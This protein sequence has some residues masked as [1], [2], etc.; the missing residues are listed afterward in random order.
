MLSCSTRT[1]CRL[2]A[3]PGGWLSRIFKRGNPMSP[4]R[5]ARLAL[6][7]GCMLI[8]LGVA[9]G[10]LVADETKEREEPGLLQVDSQ[11]T[12]VPPLVVRWEL[13]PETKQGILQFRPHRQIYLLPVRYSTATNDQPESPRTGSP[14]EVALDHVEAKFQLS[15]KMKTLENLFGDRADL[16]FAFTQQSSWQ[17]YNDEIS[18]PFRETNYEPEVMLAFATDYNLFGLNGRLLNLGVVH[19]SNGRAEPLSRSWNRVYVQ[20]GLVRDNFTLLVRPWYRL[21]EDRDEDDNRDI[22]EYLGYGDLE[23]VYKRR[24][25]T[26]S[27][28]VRPPLN[29]GHRGAAQL[30]YSFGGIGQMKGYVQIFT[31][32]GESL[33]DYNHKQTTIGAGLILTDKL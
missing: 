6:Y 31:G 8:F 30:D 13:D 16:W 4:I 27:L 7:L 11:G 33:I 10:T 20:V 1:I 17:V 22:D 28:L 2:A 24:D 29:A 26:I 25:H 12:N 23:A 14:P 5:A 21:P 15:F 32:Y 9:P 18:R 19:E 3:E